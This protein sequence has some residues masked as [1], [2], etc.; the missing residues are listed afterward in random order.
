MS[1]KKSSRKRSRKDQETPSINEPW[2]KRQT[3]LIVI[4]FVSLALAV[5]IGWQ[6]YPAVGPL[7]AVLWGGGF[8]V[9]VWAVFGFML[10][11]NKTVRRN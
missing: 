11:F 2:I 4:T 9:G 8:A 3:G 7:K 5:Y 10:L 1:D 6:V